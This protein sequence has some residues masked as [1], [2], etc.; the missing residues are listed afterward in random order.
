[1]LARD[2][3]KND[4]EWID[5]LRVKASECNY[6]EQNSRPNEQLINGINDDNMNIEI[7]RELTAIKKTS[8]ITSE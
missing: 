3:N 6:K 5:H 1:M 7:I 2:K 4:K 8:E